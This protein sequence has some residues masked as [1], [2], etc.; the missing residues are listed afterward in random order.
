MDDC[1]LGIYYA[2]LLVIYL[3]EGAKNLGKLDNNPV[4]ILNPKQVRVY[5]TWRVGRDYKRVDIYIY[6]TYRRG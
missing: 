6:M 3:I 2:I 5:T 1:L 4:R